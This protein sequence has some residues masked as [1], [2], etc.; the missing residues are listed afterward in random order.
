MEFQNKYRLYEYYL[1]HDSGYGPQKLYNAPTG[2][3]DQGYNFKRSSEYYGMFREFSDQVVTFTKEGRR[4]LLKILENQGIEA[5]CKYVVKKFNFTTHLYDDYFNGYID[6]STKKVTRKTFECKIIDSTFEATIRNREES[7]VQLF[8]LL[9]KDRQQMV[10]YTNEDEFITLPERIDY[11][12]ST[13]KSDKDENYYYSGYRGIVPVLKVETKEDDNISDADNAPNEFA[14]AFYRNNTGESISVEIDGNA[15]FTAYGGGGVLYPKLRI[16]NS[17]FTLNNE[18]NLELTAEVISSSGQAFKIRFSGEID[19]GFNMP[20]N[21]Y[22]AMY[23]D[24]QGTG[25]VRIDSPLILDFTIK[26]QS[27]TIETDTVKGML[28]HEAFNRIIQSY[29]NT[30]NAFYSELLGRTDSEPRSY[31]SDGDLAL[32]ALMNGKLFRGFTTDESNLTASLKDFYETINRLRCACLTIE[33]IGGQKVVRVEDMKYAFDDRIILTIDNAKDISFEVNQDWI[34]N[35]IKAGYD[36]AAYEE[37][38]GLL[39]YNNK[40]EYTSTIKTVKNTLDLVCPYRAD[41]EG[42]NQCR[43][44]PKSLNPTTDSEFDEDNFILDL[45]RNENPTEIVNGDFSSLT[46]WSTTG[47]VNLVTILGNQRAKISNTESTLYQS[48]VVSND[49]SRKIRFSYQL[50]SNEQPAFILGNFVSISFQVKITDGLDTYY[51]NNLG[52]WTNSEL[53]IIYSTLLPI[54]Q[55][56]IQNFINYEIETDTLP[57]IGTITI[58]F[59][60]APL[61]IFGNI[62]DAFVI[63]DD[64]YMAE[65]ARYTAR[66]NEGFDHIQN[67][68]NNE[69][70][71]NIR[72]SPGR[73]IRNWGQII[74]S[75]LEKYLSSYLSY[76]RADKNSKM[77]SKLTGESE[78]AENE[79]IAVNTLEQSFLLPETIK[80]DAPVGI[81]EITA[82]N[83]NFT[84]DGKPKKYGIVKVRDEINPEL[85]HYGWIVK[86]NSGAKKESQNWELIMV[87]TNKIT[88]YEE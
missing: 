33:E 22:L 8:S 16:Y 39:E 46:G 31:A 84:S 49:K 80:F 13:L 56:S 51:L 66:T 5:E 25:N 17:D 67:T 85:Y 4:F 45:V 15:D 12:F 72:Y 23:L 36:K 20:A 29:T 79:D 34:F 74:R 68:L 41:N 76:D 38:N 6:F 9:T 30:Q 40:S 24:W 83:G 53:K 63:I 1:I 58:T 19:L 88:P 87:N 2:W 75:G 21:T 35:K 11:L 64:V 10:G 70:S 43:Q 48:V 86:F 73:I 77:I 18:I 82:I 60:S 42:I 69:K 50:A 27:D 32:G 47:T 37:R 14:S 78:V 3:V 59:Y 28:Y 71:F 65:Q 7:E 44:I 55:T 52:E 57:I 62:R 61:D 26:T 54:K 81:D